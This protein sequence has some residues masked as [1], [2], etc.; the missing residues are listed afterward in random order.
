M[1]FKDHFSGHSQ[2]YSVFRPRYP[3]ALY[4]QLAALCVDH[5]KAWDCATG[6]G[7]AAVALSRHFG[8][9]IATDASANQIAAATSAK[10]VH[11]AVALAESSGLDDESVDMV[12][13]AQAIH[14]FNLDA[15]AAEAGRVLK[16]QG[17]LA[18]WTYGLLSFGNGLDPF[19]RKFDHIVSDY[20]DFD[21]SIVDMG[22]ANIQL[23]LAVVPFETMQMQEQWAFADL[24]GYFNTWSA[25]RTYTQQHGKSPLEFVQNDILREWGDPELKRTATWPLYVRVWRKT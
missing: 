1:T 25:L 18:A 12:S 14:W 2:A 8:E 17:I 9:V 20:W 6:S 10:G 11:Y 7:Q 4:S 21:R 22:Y 13:V 5:N 16:P 3:T 15:F 24:I 19:I 23:P